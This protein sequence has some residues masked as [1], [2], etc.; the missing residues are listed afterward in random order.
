MRIIVTGAEGYIGRHVVESLSRDHQILSTDITATRP[1]TQTLDVT[2]KHAVDE[3]FRSH[4]DAEMVVHLAAKALRKGRKSELSEYLRT[5]AEAT[6]NVAE[7]SRSHLHALRSFVLASSVAVYGE[8]RG[9]A[10]VETDE[11]KPAT[12]YAISKLEAE[13]IVRSLLPERAR[14]LRFSPVYGPDNTT[15][16]ERRVQLFGRTFLVGLGDTSTTLLDVRNIAYLMGFLALGK[17][18]AGT[19]NVSD[20][21][22]YT[23]KMIM[24]RLGKDASEATRIPRFVVAALAGLG[25]VVRSVTV[26]EAASK[27]L[28]PHVYPADC[29]CRY[30]RL[31]FSLH[32]D[33]RSVQEIE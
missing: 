12:P 2:D 13:S 28:L 31:P 23:Y 29:L 17:V 22:A 7:A 4:S 6:R 8:E 14:I 3:L 18:P 10:F 15:N 21:S 16:L 30:A 24:Q 1:E 27:L 19:Y 20:H 5:N 33:Q 25:K 26:S 32:G 11:L 9:G